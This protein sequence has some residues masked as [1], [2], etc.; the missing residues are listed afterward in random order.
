MA[1]IR[2]L[3]WHSSIYMYIANLA[4]IANYYNVIISLCRQSGFYISSSSIA[5]YNSFMSP[6]W[7][8]LLP[9]LYVAN[10]ASI[11]NNIFFFLCRQSGFYG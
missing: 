2:L 7:L 4:F 10:L 3:Y 11:T 1:P 9:F 6:I 5:N 8:L